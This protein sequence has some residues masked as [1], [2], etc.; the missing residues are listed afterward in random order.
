MPLSSKVALVHDMGKRQ[1]FRGIRAFGVAT[2]HYIMGFIEI[3]LSG[4]SGYQLLLNISPT[5]TRKICVNA[6]TLVRY[7]RYDAAME[8]VSGL[9]LSSG[10]RR[11]LGTRKA[12]TSSAE[13]AA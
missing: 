5:L 13:S 7:M 8:P 12:A 9:T 6:L 1:S 2:G 11:S 10:T 4:R 3:W